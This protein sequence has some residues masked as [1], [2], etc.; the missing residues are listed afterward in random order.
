MASTR[1]AVA[2][3]VVGV[4]GLTW[5]AAA[6]AQGGPK[7][8]LPDAPE[9]LTVG[10][11]ERPL[12]VER[13]PLF[14][15]LPRARGGNQAQT[16]FQIEV[17]RDRDGQ[18]VWDSGRVASDEQ[19]YV[20]YAG[21]ALEPA[22][23]YRWRVRTWDRDGRRSAWSAAGRF[24]TGLRDQDW[25]ASWI[26]RA[27]SE[28][29]D[30]TLARKEVLVGTS[31]IVRARAYVSACHQYELRLGGQVVDR[32]PAFAYPGEGYY[33][34][35]DIGAFVQRGA[36]LA[37]GVIYHWYGRGQGRP[38]G[39]RAL[40]VR[41]V[42]EHADG[43][44]D[45]V[46]SDG[47]WRVR[48]ASQWQEGAPQRNN[49]VGDYVE[50]LDAGAIPA[51]W[52]QPGH[53][54]TGSPWAAPEVIGVHPAG[55]FTHL[56]GQEPRLR[57]TEVDPVSVRTLADGAV[58]ADFGRVIPAR[59]RIR[60]SAGQAGRRLAIQ[61]GYRL[62]ESGHID[63]SPDATQ[64]ADMSFAY[65]Q[66]AGAQEFLPFT[67]LGFRY[68]ELA[69]PGEEL[70][71]GAIQ[72]IVEHTD[73]PA[74]G[75]ATFESSDATLNAVFE[76]TQRSALHSVQQQFVDTPTREKG[77]FLHDAINQSYATMAGSLERDA[78]Q[79]AI[80]EFVQSQARYWPDGRVNAVYPNGDGKRD[81]PDFTEMLPNWAWRYYMETGDRSLLA[82]AYPALVKLADYVWQYRDAGTGLITNLA[83]GGGPY[84]HGIIDWPPSGR[85]SYDMKTAA[86]TTVNILAVDAQ[87][88]VARIA[89]S[90]GR[91]QA[92]IAL[93]EGRAADLAR[94]INDRLRR[95]DG[96][97]SDGL[98]PDGG[99]S[100]SASQHASSYA[101]AFGVA[102]RDQFERLGGHVAGLGMRQGPM[103]AHW[104]LK[105]L[106][107]SGRVDDVLA[108]LTDREGL[109]WANV[110]AQGG[111]FTWES[112]AA[113]AEG[114]SESHGWGAQALVD[115]LETLLGLRVTGPGA[116]TIDIVVPECAL[117]S[118]RGTV[119]TQRGPV[120]IDWARK[121]GGTLTLSV[122]IPVNVKAQVVLPAAP[123]AKTTATGEGAPKL[124]SK[125]GGRAV[126]EVG[127]GRT[128]FTV[129][130]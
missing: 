22:T 28:R 61:T 41:V 30:Y 101:V 56:V 29:D 77:Q 24:E 17:T 106:A 14:G 11:R 130:R 127:S 84:L 107:D 70:G 120:T 34:A 42:I 9:R 116:R 6:P 44:R 21:P 71:R 31:P 108:R 12:N 123:T 19:A 51:G 65:V 103:T 58:L 82:E 75:G 57:L 112:W 67:H 35:T 109:G 7:G 2:A 88:S 15:W 8:P 80:R 47:T 99:Q 62:A 32:G 50:H 104:L 73:A 49:D 55:P 74:D 69:V 1:T 45:V 111:T 117:A 23:A 122:S 39:E 36:P 13:A 113:R 129:S 91:P 83:G 3:L 126:Y 20:A 94:A 89:R 54:A 87:R 68:L 98:L 125:D 79:K 63:A 59:P 25:Q 38:A 114:Q 90:L 53:D 5:G 110:L 60:F 76:L 105:A 37:I 95:P 78:T 86:R 16:A 43:T 46:V 115:I 10:D 92:E 121:A 72:A 40:L 97:F 118:A 18:A 119:R 52:D 128:A 100:E 81:I 93:Y 102:P 48:R 27:S 124:V 66:T 85:F 26:R 4:L 33:Q 64:K 96:L